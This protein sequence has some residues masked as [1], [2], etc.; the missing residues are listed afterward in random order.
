MLKLFWLLF[1]SVLIYSCKSKVSKRKDFENENVVVLKQ[2]RLK[3]SMTLYFYKLVGRGVYANS[4]LSYQSEI[5]GINRN[6]FIL[7]GLFGNFTVGKNDTIMIWSMYDDCID[8]IQ[9]SPF[10]FKNVKA[11]GPHQTLGYDESNKMFLGQI[12]K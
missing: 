7:E 5:C 12:C 10:I 9:P 8:S 3:D 4:Y 11:T 2:E 6:N 1:L